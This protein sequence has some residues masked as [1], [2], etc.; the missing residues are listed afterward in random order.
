MRATWSLAGWL[1]A[2]TAVAAVL[3]FRPPAPLSAQEPP[4]EAGLAQEIA[5][6]FAPVYYLRLQERECDRS[7]EAYDPAP[8]ELVLGGDPSIRLRGI[9]GG[10][11]RG[12]SGEDLAGREDPAHLDFPGDPRRPGCR[13]E[14]DYRRLAEGL[15]PAVYA[16]VAREPGRSGFAIQYWAFYYFNDWNNTHEGDWEMVSLVFEVD[17]IQEGLAAGPAFAAYAEHGSGERQDWESK[18]IVKEGDRPVV[19]VSAG[20]HASYFRPDTYL[21][22]GEGGSGL[23]CDIATGPHRRLD[24]Q[25][26]LFREPGLHPG[27][28]PWLTFGGRWGELV[29]KEFN[30]PRGPQTKRAWREPISWAEELRTGSA[31][32]PGHDLLG[33]D[34]VRTFCRAVSEGSRLLRAFFQFPVIVGGSV[35]LVL[36]TMSAAGLVILKDTVRNPMVGG[37]GFLRRRRTFGQMLTATT[38][39]YWRRPRVF[40]GLSLAFIPVE[41]LFSLLHDWIFSIPPFENVLWLFNANQVSRITMALLL[42]GL[43]S[44]VVYVAVVTAAIAAVDGLD[45]GQ[46][47]TIRWAY[48]QALRRIGHAAGARARALLVIGLLGL[49]IVGIPVAIWLAVRWNFIEEAAVIDRESFWSAPGASAIG[50]EGRFFRALAASVLFGVF[51]A[52]AGPLLAIAL[53]LGTGLDA[54]FVNVLSGLFHAAALPYTAIG[55]SLA[56]CDLRIR[57][58]EAPAGRRPRQRQ[59]RG[60]IRRVLQLGR[61]ALRQVLR[62]W[63]GR[64]H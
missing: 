36:G 56:Y 33:M 19:Y 4:G 7:G 1:I 9:P 13:F 24:P 54:A 28:M 44:L 63:E 8:V 42:G 62:L 34:N 38:L 53:L 58:A 47:V 29:E 16:R 26:I 20:S 45:R 25:V 46:P 30:G 59:S 23:G 52:L 40:L 12:P 51:G 15:E 17:S 57:A 43:A 64:R 37:T 10:E 60:R 61:S 14:R 32:L 49:S 18:R 41:L 11:I 21:G 50:V 2:G 35:V 22:L 31:T 5:E 3:F 27:P 39:L 6:R 48:R 55:L